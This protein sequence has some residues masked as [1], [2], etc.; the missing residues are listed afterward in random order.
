MNVY[1]KGNRFPPELNRS[2]C[3]FTVSLIKNTPTLIAEPNAAA[4]ELTGTGHTEH[5]S[6]IVDS[7]EL[8]SRTP[9]LLVVLG[10]LKVEWGA[11]P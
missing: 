7:R 4:R 3:A 8:Q 6:Y 1:V 11:E 9:G 10:Y 2:L 5:I